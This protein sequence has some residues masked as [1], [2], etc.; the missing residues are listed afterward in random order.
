MSRLPA[1]PTEVPVHRSLDGLAPKFRAA[2]ERVLTA[3]RADGHDP[4]VFE[5]IRTDAR[6]E[7]LHGFGRA[8]DDGRGVVTHSQSA[9]DT[10][11]GYGLAVD[12]V[13]G[14]RRWAAGAGF[15]TSL[16]THARR[17]GLVWGADWNSNGR[18][19]DERF[20]DRPHVQ[21]GNGMRRSPSSKAM[22]LQ[23]TGGNPAVWAVVGA[24]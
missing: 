10:W 23:L 5:T 8:Y 13:S 6:Q 2:V 11:H 21:W 22:A 14:S 9:A 4:V 16:G 1:P 20:L 19:D 24:A 3:M 17:E 18:S 12:I 15:W 7:F